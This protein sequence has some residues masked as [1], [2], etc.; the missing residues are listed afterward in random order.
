LLTTASASGS[1]LAGLLEVALEAAKFRGRKGVA[2]RG[3]GVSER[4]SR[5]ELGGR[6]VP[7]ELVRRSGG[8]KGIVSSVSIHS[9]VL[10]CRREATPFD[11][12]R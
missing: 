2:L 1:P 6:T 10:R 4:E 3:T 12:L 5:C 8:G 9:V 11:R 7:A